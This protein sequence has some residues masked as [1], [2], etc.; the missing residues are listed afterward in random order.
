ML[1]MVGCSSVSTLDPMIVDERFKF[2][3]DA[4]TSRQEVLDRLGEPANRYEDGLILTYLIREDRDRRFRVVN[5]GTE[6]GPA[7]RSE[8][9]NLVLVFGPDGRLERHS[10]VRVR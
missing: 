6:D 9:Y 1:W 4:T 7:F 5:P 10:V 8:I 2:I 3:R